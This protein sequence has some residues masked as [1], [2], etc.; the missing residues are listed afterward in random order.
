[1]CHDNGDAR[2]NGDYSTIKETN[3]IVGTGGVEMPVFM[4]EPEG[5]SRGQVIVISD[6]W[7]ANDF[8]HDL[9]RR[10]AVAGFTA[11]LPDMF[12]RQGPLAEQ[13]HEAARARGGL[14]DYP[15]ALN[16]IG[17]II[18]HQG[19]ERGKFGVIGFCM[20]GTMVM[21][22]A[23]KDQRLQCGVI[24]YGF[25]A[26]RAVTALRPTEPL[27]ETSLV[28]MPLLGFWGDQDHGVGMVNVEQYDRQ[29]TDA[30]KEHEFTIY[31][32]LPHAFMTFDPSGT[33]YK[34]SA[35]SWERTLNWF[36][37]RLA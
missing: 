34:E 2:P 24:Y 5:T 12:V 8:Y 26:N 7:G 13:T 1:M 17:A 4:A 14:L 37:E 31:P 9:S 22:L 35:E 10:L 23:S 3:I 30:G 16:D 21:H 6:I 32:G 29:L 18:D 20:G 33:W 19:E 36:N 15:Q 27:R 11:Y 25:P 28:Q